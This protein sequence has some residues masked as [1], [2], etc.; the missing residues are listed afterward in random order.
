[1]RRDE[2]TTFRSAVSL[3]WRSARR[4]RRPQKRQPLAGGKVDTIDII[5]PTRGFREIDDELCR[6]R[7]AAAAD[8]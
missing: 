4:G 8:R 7:R 1:M 2:I 5:K 6:M 3:R